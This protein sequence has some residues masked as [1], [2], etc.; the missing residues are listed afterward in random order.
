MSNDP[1]RAVLVTGA[2]TGIGW[3]TAELLASRGF[4]V[5][6]GLRRRAP[7]DSL[8]PAPPGCEP[9]ELDVTSADNVARAASHLAAGAEV[10][11]AYDGLA[12]VLD[13][14]GRAAVEA[15]PQSTAAEQEWARMLAAAAGRMLASGRSAILV[16]PD[17]RDLDRLLAALA[18]LVPA[19]AIVRH[20]SRQTNPD[21]Y[22]AFLRTLEDA[23]CVVV[24]NRSAVYAPVR[25]GL[26][27]GHEQRRRAEPVEAPVQ[28]ARVGRLER[29]REREERRRAVERG[30]VEAAEGLQRLDD[31]RRRD[32]HDLEHATKLPRRR[33]GDLSSLPGSR[34]RD[35]LRG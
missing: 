28:A 10:L 23:P 26:V 22:R 29:L 11:A 20:D 35:R 19:E 4:R 31:L 8:P 30:V 32:H 17:H 6:A 34:R 3:A 13:E 33:R 27:E 12:E 5:L 16:V 7:A 2:S 24:G 14:G 15:I 21:R 1:P 9:I 18:T 25:A